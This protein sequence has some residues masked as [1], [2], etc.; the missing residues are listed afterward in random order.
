MEKAVYEKKTSEISETSEILKLK[1]KLTALEKDVLNYRQTDKMLHERLNESRHYQ[2][3]LDALL[4]ASKAILEQRGFKATARSIFDSCKELIGATAGYVALLDESGSENRVLFLESGGLPC[5]VDPVLPMPIRGLRAEAYLNNKVVFDND[6]PESR[7]MEF[8]PEG[9]VRLENVMFSPLIIEGKSVGLIGLA[10]KP[11]GF[12]EADAGI[13]SAFGQLAAIALLNSM[14]LESLKK[15]ED[16][17]RMISELTSDYIFK[18]RVNPDSSMILDSISEEFTHLTGYT[19][20]ELQAADILDKLI[21]SDDLKSLKNFLKTVIT[22]QRME[23]ECRIVSKTGEKRWLKIFGQPEWSDESHKEVTAIIGAAKDITEQTETRQKIQDAAERD[24][25]QRGKLDMAARVLHDIGNAMTGLS[26]TV[27]KLLGETKWHENIELA[28]LERMVQQK[29]NQIAAALGQGKDEALIIFVRE[30][31][32]SLEDRRNQL[33]MDHQSM[34]KTVSH[35]NEILH[36]QR[37]YVSVGSNLRPEPTTSVDVGELIEDALSINSGAIE[38][39]WIKIW[40]NIPAEIPLIS[41]DRTQLIQV[42]INII[43]NITEAFDVSEKLNDRILDVTVECSDLSLQKNMI[44]I[45]LSDNA[46]GFEE[47]DA[48]R[49]FEPGFTTKNRGTGMGLHQCR[50]IIENH[51]GI[52]QINSPG[53]G[54]GTRTI[55]ELPTDI[56][57]KKA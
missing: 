1:E 36:L 22:G 13:A 29:R 49:L 56:E 47:E 34:A 2:K 50:T 45:I 41:G 6:F 21:Y 53:K 27:T 10:N 14:T 7:W 12:T 28:K 42:F 38:K 23:I 40:R 39:R 32:N 15:S 9:H 26:T 30:L 20:N 8:M 57:D 33:A 35:I 16:R 24:A 52:I 17:F 51:R 55:I 4:S 18:I 19:L 31:K 25:I 5:T 3:E 46:V 48:A 44:K 43:K 54:M 11:E 37:R